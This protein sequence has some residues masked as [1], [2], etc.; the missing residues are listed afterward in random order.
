[1]HLTEQKPSFTSAERDRPTSADQVEAA[2]DALRPTDV[3]DAIVQAATDYFAASASGIT[4][5][6]FEAR[7][8]A[9]QV[10]ERI[11]PQG[12]Q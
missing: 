7:Y 3:Y 1:M 4:L 8:I 10:L 2:A 12:V 6:P 11:C 5:A 9:A